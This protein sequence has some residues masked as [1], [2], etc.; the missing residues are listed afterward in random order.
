MCS[1]YQPMRLDDCRLLHLLHLA[2]SALPIGTLAHSFGLET[3]VA[4]GVLS[5]EQLELFLKDVVND[6]G[7]L[8]S[9]FCRSSYRLAS[10]S[11]AAVFEAQWL[12]LN[13]Q[14]CAWKTARE[15]RT[16]SATLGR[17]LLQL[18]LD[19]EAHPTIQ[20]PLLAAQAAGGEAHYSSAF[21]LVGGV[22]GTGENATV[23]A[24]LRQFLAGLVS[25][26]QRLMPLGQSQAG[27][28]LWRLY[29]TLIT[30]AGRSEAAAPTLDNAVL[31]T[32]LPDLGSMRHPRLTTRLF[33][34]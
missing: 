18:A 4:E 14:I 22:L 34:S 17:R 24:Y 21:G 8:E 13:E 30:I 12:S 25:C 32:P 5:V 15:S 6:V 27:K 11:N 26:C 7:C 29:P 20:S 3:M 33:I 23:V 16:A 31:F 19:L 2:D 1:E 10:P 9:T 28:M